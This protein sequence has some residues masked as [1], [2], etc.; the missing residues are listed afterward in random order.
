MRAVCLRALLSLHSL[1][2]RLRALGLGLLIGLCA[3]RLD[4]LCDRGL[5]TWNRAARQPGTGLIVVALI[6]ARLIAT[7]RRVAGGGPT[8]HLLRNHASIP[9]AIRPHLALRR[10]LI[11]PLRLANGIITHVRLIRT[12]TLI[13]I[14]R[15]I[16]AVADIRLICA[17][18]IR[19]RLIAITIVR[20]DAMQA[21]GLIATG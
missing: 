3:L 11:A 12:A 9:R 8:I 15:T 14:A 19:T 17:G 2:V 16:R 13:H 18:L 5:V 4:A 1:L 10:P 21:L 20:L 7:R 6:V